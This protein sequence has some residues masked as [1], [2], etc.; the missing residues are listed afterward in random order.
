MSDVFE[1]FRYDGFYDEIVETSV[2]EYAPIGC[3]LSALMGD[4]EYIY[5]KTYQEAVKYRRE[6]LEAQ[7][8]EIKE[9][10]SLMDKENT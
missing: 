7:L 9:K 5:T 3:W 8:E 1:V 6:H 2:D 10:L 4:G